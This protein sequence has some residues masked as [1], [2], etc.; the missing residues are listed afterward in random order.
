MQAGLG[1]HVLEAMLQNVLGQ[2]EHLNWQINGI[3]RILARVRITLYDWLMHHPD[4]NRWQEA[5]LDLMIGES[6]NSVGWHTTHTQG[7]N[8]LAESQRIRRTWQRDMRPRIPVLR[9]RHLALSNEVVA[10]ENLWSSLDVLW[11]QLH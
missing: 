5:V 3:D 1:D 11:S 9:Q 6:V 7:N 2:I 4:A 8:V 10:L